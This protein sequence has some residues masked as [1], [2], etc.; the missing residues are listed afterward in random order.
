MTKKKIG[1]IVDILMYTLMLTQMLYVFTTNN[2]HEVLGVLF[3]IC[4]VIHL[5]IKG[6]WFKSAFRKGQSGLRLL[7]NIITV[8]LL[9]STA[10]LMISSD[11]WR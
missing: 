11:R 9:L 7:F 3:F 2:V 4:L 5:I 10:T 6:W 8:L 1:M